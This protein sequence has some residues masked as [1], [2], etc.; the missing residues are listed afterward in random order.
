MNNDLLNNALKIAEDLG[1]KM[2]DL[3]N[4]QTRAF[5]QLPPEERAKIKF[6]ENDIAKMK[7]AFK[8]G[9]EKTINDLMLKYADI[10]N[11]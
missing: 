4:L 7:K 8:D 2:D 6:V 9:D 10:N 3:M 11:Q 5:R 1:S